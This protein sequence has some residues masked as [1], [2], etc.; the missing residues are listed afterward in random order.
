MADTQVK[1]LV[2]VES[3]AKAKTIEK[4]LGEGFVVQ[5]SVG[6]IRDLPQRAA[7]VPKEFKKNKWASLGIDIENDFE[8]L[9]VVDSAKQ[10]RVNDLKKE[11]KEADELI[12]ATDE[13]RE[14]EA[15]AWHLLEVLRP[16]VPVKRMV[17]NEIT[18]EAIQNAVNNTRD[19]DQNLVDAQES[20][21]LI[22]RLYGYQVSPILWKKVGRGL[23]A[24][25]VQSVAVRLVV[26]KERE[27]IAFKAADYWDIDAVFDPGSFEAKLFSVDGKRIAQGQDFDDK[28][29]L[30]KSDV[31]LLT[32]NDV[33]EIVNGLKDAK[34]E[35]TDVS[36]RPYSRKPEAPFMTS[37]LQREA[38]NKYGW[39]AKRTMRTAQGLYERGFI[40]YMRT[41]S[42]T[43]SESAL[44]AARNQARE[45]FGADHVSSE[46]R[47]YERKVKNAQEAH[48]AVRPAGDV[49]KTPAELSSEL[50]SDDFT[51]YEM[52]WRRT[53]ASQMVDAKGTTSTVKISGKTNN[54]KVIEFSASGTVIEFLGYK[55]AYESG[56]TDEADE[57][58]E[59]R[60]PSLKKSDVLT[61]KEIKPTGHQTTPPARFT[62]ASLVKE[63]EA[64]GIGRPSTYASILGTIVD[65]GYILR[66]GR[67]LVPSWTAFAVIRLLEEF[68]TN[69]V[70]YAFTARMEEELD[71]VA[72]GQL[73]R[74][75]ALRDFY[76]GPEDLSAKGLVTLLEQL[77]DIDARG[78]STFEVAD[79]GIS[80]RVGKYGPYLER[81]EERASIPPD[82]APD[83]LTPE[84]AL[85]ILTAPSTDREL[86]VHPETGLT[87]MVKTGRYGPYFTEVLPEDSTEKP[88]TASLLKSME[89]STVTLDDALKLFA[90]P[91]VIGIDP[92][93][94]LEITAQNG[95]YGPYMTKGKDSRSLDTEEQIFTINLEEA[96]AKYALP[97]TRR[98]AVVKPPLR[99]VGL[100]PSTQLMMVIKEGRFGPYVTDGET[101]A[102]LRVGDD[103][104]T[105]SIERAS[106]LLSDR[107]ARGPVE[108][109][110]KKTA[111]KTTA[112]KTSKKKSKKSEV[113]EQANDEV[114]V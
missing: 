109:K 26:E 44:N 63:L 95:R 58:E 39:S 52:I 51:L 97:K 48:E 79:S 64:R 69:L 20:R 45:L 82:V 108:K 32:E 5:A 61:A 66:K 10:S 65:R 103:I 16:K 112:K 75:Q 24:G 83:E 50:K 62:E 86:G 55:A 11:L 31:V 14:G 13:D 72:A 99:E 29:N 114:S 35:V 9:Y 57:A 28:G 43:L 60:L 100:D 54:G 47:R 96:L 89:P 110:R 41:D 92:S 53:V 111:K 46:P 36:S 42:T 18:K 91:R 22:D 67:A 102:S 56:E 2:I 84:R 76:F 38:S 6:H 98:G 1:K 93:D 27:R 59:K 71:L 70:D 17:F 8:P 87:I 106:E 37:T 90:L 80:V 3:P 23:S 25:R 7:E 74:S 101:N 40:T 94:N 30:T 19:I 73:Q 85:A 77:P 78:N 104:P 113:E 34:F 107:R 88:R 4:Y 68:F 21:R 49:F 12:L 81:G 105:M 33:T 15:I